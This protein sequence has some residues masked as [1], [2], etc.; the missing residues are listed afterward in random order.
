MRILFCGQS[1]YPNNSNA[2][3]N[4]YASIAKTMAMDNEVIFV[5]RIPHFEKGANFKKGE[6]KV[7]DASGL[8]YRPDSFL[9][10]NF[11]KFFSPIYELKTFYVLNKEKKIDFKGPLSLIGG[12]MC[13]RVLGKLKF[14]FK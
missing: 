2:T 3:S 5:N 4:R 12:F 7:V 11:I 10:R 9:K 13:H 8:T 1:Q 14:I 6:F